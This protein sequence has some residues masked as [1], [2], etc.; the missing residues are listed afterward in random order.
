VFFE[1]KRYLCKVNKKKKKMKRLLYL[2]I[3]SV[4]TSFGAAASD[5]VWNV[6]SDGDT[7]WY[8]INKE[9]KTAEVSENRSYSGSIVIPQE[10]KVKRK[11]YRV[12]GVSRYAFFYC[13]KLKSVTM[14]SGLSSIGSS[15]FVG[16]RNLEQLTIPESVT[17]IGEK[18]FDGC[19]SLRNIQ[20]SEAN[21]NYCSV[22]GALYDK[23]KETL[24]MVFQNG[25]SKF[26]IPESVTTIEDNAFKD[27]Q[28]LTNIVIPNSV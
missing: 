15:A 14:P 18:A 2:I 3:C 22:D 4:L 8:D 16:C 24:I 20:V 10:I 17:S 25:I 28:N 21:Q 23:S 5:K 7:I 1:K 27:C 9:T 12:T 13:N 26:V 6:N 11:T 19:S